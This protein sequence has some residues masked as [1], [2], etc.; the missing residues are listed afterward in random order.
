ME[1]G[2]FAFFT[3]LLLEKRDL[4]AD[5]ELY[6]FSDMTMGLGK[7][8]NIEIIP[9]TIFYTKTDIVTGL[10]TAGSFGLVEKRE[11]V[12]MSEILMVTSIIMP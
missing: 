2:A 8:L 1:D 12:I 3:I 6:V 4:V 11:S 10:L 7:R 9:D 5:S